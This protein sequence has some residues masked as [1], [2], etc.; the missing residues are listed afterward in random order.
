MFSIKMYFVLGT[1]IITLGSNWPGRALTADG[2]RG[3]ALASE[4]A[5]T[6]PREAS[7]D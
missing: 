3:A 4:L 7:S 6:L 5:N 1:G 2:R